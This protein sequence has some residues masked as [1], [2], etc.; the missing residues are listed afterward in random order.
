MS[1]AVKFFE[2]KFYNFDT[3]KHVKQV[4]GNIFLV[5]NIFLIS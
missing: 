4:I 1:A 5:E 3:R 2:M